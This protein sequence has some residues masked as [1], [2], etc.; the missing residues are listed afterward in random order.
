MPWFPYIEHEALSDSCTLMNMAIAVVPNENVACHIF[1]ISC[2][3][4]LKSIGLNTFI[5]QEPT[6][7]PRVGRED[8][9]RVGHQRRIALDDFLDTDQDTVLQPGKETLAN[10][11]WR[12]VS[13]SRLMTDA[14][15]RRFRCSTGAFIARPYVISLSLAGHL[16]PL[17]CF[18]VNSESDAQGKVFSHYFEST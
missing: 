3:S 18:C 6:A 4:F 17:V 8:V 14:S 16:I 15:A 12:F 1:S 13:F 5:G 9:E 7:V 11:T 2:K 10:P